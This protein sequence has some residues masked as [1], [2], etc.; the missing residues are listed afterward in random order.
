L[1][2][3]KRIAIM[4]YYWPP[5][6]GSGV[7]RWLFLANYFA[8]NG[9][10]ISVF[11]PD[12]PRIAQRDDA[13]EQKVHAEIT[14]IKVAGWEPLQHSKKPIGE[15]LGEKPGV[16]KR[17]MLW[18]RA[19]FFIP[20]ARVY[21]ANAAAQVFFKYHKETPYDLIITSGPPHSLH[22]IG[23]QAKQQTGVA[24]VADFRDPWTGFFQNRSLPLN[25]RTRQKH[26]Y[27][28]QKVL[29]RA[30]HVVVT[31]PSLKEDFIV[32]NH[33]IDVLTNG[34]EQP[35]A[36]ES[37]PT[38]GMV[39][40]GSL[41]AQQNPT[42]LWKSI[43]SLIK[44]NAAFSIAF[45]L[46]IYGKVATSIKAEIKSLGIDSHVHFLDYQ[47][48]EIIDAQLANAK[49]LLL[50]GINM[51][52]TANVIHGKLFEYMAAQRPVL[53]IGPKPSD[54]QPLFEKHQLGVYASFDEA[55]LI[56]KTLINW[57]VNNDLPQPSKSIASYE[58]NVIAQKYLDL[59]RLLT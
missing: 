23:L 27:L 5:S 38:A 4:V 36:T 8:A 14:E 42:A 16:L 32:H 28:E 54:M 57:F 17:F 58:R 9:L 15:N 48:K 53:G 11:V 40:A 45:S 55:A 47:P 18:V 22:L 51:P 59:I 6:G 31:A 13:L 41:K 44:S 46:D 26:K 43:A 49:S 50:L 3:I 30:D 37:V 20:D 35:L 12:N 19:N 56:E 52:M 29:Q 10:D 7:Q 2:D 34:Y 24:W 21:W 39:Y 1:A 33:N 25:K